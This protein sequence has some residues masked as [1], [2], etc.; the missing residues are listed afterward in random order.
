[1]LESSAW[2]SIGHQQQCLNRSREW[3]RSS[4]CGLSRISRTL[5]GFLALFAAPSA[6]A[7]DN[8]T[9]QPI[10]SKEKIEM[11]DGVQLDICIAKPPKAQSK[12]KFPVLLTVDGYSSPCGSF[13]RDWYADYVRSGYVVAYLNI[14]G[15]GGSQ[16]ELAN[17]EY[18]PAELEDTTEAVDWLAQQPWSTGRIGM[19]GTS[20]SGFTAMLVGA[21]RPPALKAIVTFMATDNTYAEDVRYPSGIL[22]MDD[23]TV[24]AD[25]M[26]FVTPSEQDPFDEEVLRN[27][28]DQQPMSL[29]F[30]RQQRDGEFWHRS[31]RRNIEPTAGDIPTMMVGAW[32]DP[33]RNA[34]IRAL[35]YSRGPVRAVIGPWNHSSDYPGPTADLGHLTIEWWD[36]F[37]KGKQNGV[38]EKPQVSVFMRRPYRPIVSRSQIPGE[39]RSIARWSEA[40]VQQQLFFLTE[41]RALSPAAGKASD[42]HLRM[43]A[44]TGVGAGLGWIDVAPD[45]RE[46][47]STALVYESPPLSSELQILGAPVASLLSSVDVDHANWFVKLSDVA[48]DGTTSLVTG[49]GLNGAHRRSSAEPEALVVGTRYPLELKLHATSWIFQP[50]HRIRISV[51][52]ALFPAYW[53]SAKPLV[54]TLGVGQG[55]ST[56]ALPVIPP[57]SPESAKKAAIAVGS[58]NLTVADA[59]AAGSGHAGTTWNGPVR[60]QILRDDLK[61]TT[62]VTRG[63]QWASPEGEDVSVEFSV[64]DDDP[65]K[66]SFVGRS[67]VKSKWQGH[68]VEW[69]GTT[70]LKS[71]TETF[72]YHHVRQLLRDG[73]VVRE[74]EW[75]ERVP[76]D[77]Q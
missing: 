11:K 34:T 60:S 75:K 67:S 49:G 71:D 62:T 74:R 5:F 23:Y 16:G 29:T 18:S 56:L 72:Y 44:S 8:E 1:M 24:A 20:W 32:H 13:G 39:W 66:A 70:E 40:P 59:E 6:Y 25:S 45:Q 15:T 54:M 58:R 50:G 22:H 64:A 43:V 65:A 77:F 52:N 48:P 37:L 9:P 53:P 36:Y 14:R 47:D 28:F 10:F 55:G 19:F 7:T 33:Y 41:N 61:R 51:S 21:R 30:L 2:R 3:C 31:S 57:Q 73:H 26:L 46:G 38:L 69:R 27:R 42:H 17:R 12:Q 68:D 4:V 35:E 76:R 63:F